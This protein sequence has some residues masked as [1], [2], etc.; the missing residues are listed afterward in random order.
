[1]FIEPFRFPVFSRQGIPAGHESVTDLDTEVEANAEGGTERWPKYQGH[2]HL[3]FRGTDPFLPAF[4][5]V[6]GFGRR[7]EARVAHL[8]DRVDF[9]GIVLSF[10]IK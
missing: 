7:R 1:M 5:W 8:N 2:F 4:G 6:L 3:S 10:E 9:D